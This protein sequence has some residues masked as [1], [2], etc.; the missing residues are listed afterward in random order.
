MIV[1]LNCN[2]LENIHGWT[3]VFMAKAYC[4]GYFTGIVSWLLIDPRKVWNFST[5]EWFAM[6]GTLSSKV[7]SAYTEISLQIQTLGL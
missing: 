3:V 6:Y 5:S 2:S 7:Q 1:K 4:I